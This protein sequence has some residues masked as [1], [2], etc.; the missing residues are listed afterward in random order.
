VS[1]GSRA[2]R[3]PTTVRPLLRAR[4]RCKALCRAKGSAPSVGHAA[5]AKHQTLYDAIRLYR[6][7]VGLCG[8]AHEALHVLTAGPTEEWATNPRMRYRTLPD[9]C[10]CR[11]ASQRTKS[12]QEE[13]LYEVSYGNGEVRADSG[14]GLVL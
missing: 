2:V 6:E 13:A 14:V 10:S 7:N 1:P 9:L 8:A 12:N 4:R 3:D 11:L 5:S